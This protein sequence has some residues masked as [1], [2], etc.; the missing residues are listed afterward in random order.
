MKV[1]RLDDYIPIVLWP[2]GN[3]DIDIDIIDI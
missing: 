1:Y 3:I 2:V